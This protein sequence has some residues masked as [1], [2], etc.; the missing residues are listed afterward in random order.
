MPQNL[1]LGLA[2]AS[3]AELAATKGGPDVDELRAMFTAVLRSSRET[4]R[5]PYG[6]LPTRRKVAGNNLSAGSLRLAVGLVAMLKK[7]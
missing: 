7:L 5:Q 3:D 6:Y 4:Y 1:L 2:I